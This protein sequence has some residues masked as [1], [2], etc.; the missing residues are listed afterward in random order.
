MSQKIIDC[1]GF[2]NTSVDFFSKKKVVAD[3]ATSGDYTY[4]RF[5]LDDVGPIHRIKNGETS[6]NIRWAYGSWT[7][8]ETLTYSNDLNTPVTLNV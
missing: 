2:S 6:S 1:Y 5:S 4:L 3:M 8:R 7:A